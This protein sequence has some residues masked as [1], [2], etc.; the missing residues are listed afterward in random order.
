MPNQAEMY[1]DKIHEAVKISLSMELN[2]F[3]LS[4]VV[5]GREIQEHMY[6]NLQNGDYNPVQDVIDYLVDIGYTVTKHYEDGAFFT[7]MDYFVSWPANADF[8]HA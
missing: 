5:G 6:P 3:R 2:Q 1:M 8:V 7:D 4:M